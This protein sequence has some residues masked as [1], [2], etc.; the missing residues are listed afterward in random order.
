MLIRAGEEEFPVE[1]QKDIQVE[2]FLLEVAHLSSQ[3]D[4][5]KIAQTFLK[6]NGIALI[7][8][9][10]LPRTY[11]DGAA[12]LASDGRPVIGLT[13]RHDRLDNFWHT[14]LHELV[15]VCRHLTDPGESFADNLDADQPRDPKEK[16]ADQLAREAFIPSAKW[17]RCDARFDPTSESI[18]ELAGIQRIHPAIVAGWIRH[19]TKN[20]Y[21]F[22]N[23]IGNG[24][25]R[26][27]FPETTWA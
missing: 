20:Y 11:L 2:D 27:L 22:G 24:Q 25:V 6:E 19:E 16:E 7:I 21:Q 13:I 23:L 17:E 4:G 15:H 1:F 3:V 8:E 5:P 9:P 12:I 14:L 26:K 18:I 10:H